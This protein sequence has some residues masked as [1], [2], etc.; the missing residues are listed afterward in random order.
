MVAD[1]V[2]AREIIRLGIALVE[3]PKKKGKVSA[4]R[5]KE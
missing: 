5:K 2:G 3:D 4:S 1:K